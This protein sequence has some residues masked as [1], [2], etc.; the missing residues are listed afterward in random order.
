MPLILMFVFYKAP[1]QLICISVSHQAQIEIGA[2]SK[3][4]SV[5]LYDTDQAYRRVNFP[6]QR[7]NSPG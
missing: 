6:G 4:K 2:T 3:K 5:N 1:V 7:M